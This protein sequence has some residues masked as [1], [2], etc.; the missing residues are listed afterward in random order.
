MKRI[1]VSLRDLWDNITQ[2]TIQIIEVLEDKVKV[3]EKIFQE[4]IVENLPNVRKKIVNQVQ[5]VQR[6]VYQVNPRRNMLRHILIKLS[7]IKYKEKMLKAARENQQITY[8]GIPITLSTNISAETL[9]AKSKQQNIFKVIK[10]KTY[11]QDY[12]T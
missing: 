7:K 5:E 4:T 9:Q 10:G 3:S 2:T 6:V 8:K 12:S 11:N 1:A